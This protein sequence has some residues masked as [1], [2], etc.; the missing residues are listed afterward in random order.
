MGYQTLNEVWLQVLDFIVA[1]QSEFGDPE[2]VVREGEVSV[3]YRTHRSIR[4]IPDGSES[5]R[6]YS[7]EGYLVIVF[8]WEY[9]PKND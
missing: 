6:A 7:D 1:N 2:V 5:W 3:C 8:K 4:S 9:T